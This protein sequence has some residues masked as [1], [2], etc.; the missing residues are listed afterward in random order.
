M[1]FSAELSATSGDWP[2]RLSCIT[3]Y[4]C[5]YNSGHDSCLVC[6]VEMQHRSQQGRTLK[7]CASCATRT[8]LMLLRT[9]LPQVQSCKTCL[10]I[11][12]VFRDLLFCYYVL[13]NRTSGLCLD[14]FLDASSTCS[15]PQSY[16]IWTSPNLLG[17]LVDA[18]ASEDI[19][20]MW[21]QLVATHCCFVSAKS[22]WHP[23][24]LETHKFH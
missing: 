23:L 16:W 15:S 7:A 5:W 6:F 22:S 4:T 3:R 24:H 10:S 21:R 8:S 18:T 9:K 14:N 19:Q 17:A 13:T 20:K 12:A 11:I 1:A 2:H